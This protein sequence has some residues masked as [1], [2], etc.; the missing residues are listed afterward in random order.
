MVM[1][2]SY[3]INGTGTNRGSGIIDA[4]LNG[5]GNYQTRFVNGDYRA[6]GFLTEH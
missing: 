6:Q 5:S 3:N 2:I 4:R 1:R